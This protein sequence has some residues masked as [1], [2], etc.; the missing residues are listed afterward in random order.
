MAQ[1]R[2]DYAGAQDI[3]GPYGCG[4][5]GIH[6]SFNT[7]KFGRP[8]DGY[9]T[10]CKTLKLTVTPA[11]VTATTA[12]AGNVFLFKFLRYSYRKEIKSFTGFRIDVFE[13]SNC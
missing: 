3:S 12:D 9:V 7:N 11:P 10:I 8:S 4:Y 13:G 1:Q 2:K 5:Q 6:A